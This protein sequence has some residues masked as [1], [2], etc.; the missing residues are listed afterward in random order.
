MNTLQR[1]KVIILA[2]AVLAVAFGLV[3]F[4]ITLKKPQQR[5]QQPIYTTPT[6]S[7]LPPTAFTA[8]TVVGFSPVDQSTNIS[9][10]ASVSAT[11]SRP[12]TEAEKQHVS[13]ATAPVT[14]GSLNWSQNNTV[15]TFSPTHL[16]TNTSYQ[17]S[18]IFGSQ[19]IHWSFTTASD[20]NLSQ[21]DKNALQLQSDDQFGAWQQNVYNNYPWYDN[22]PLQT[23]GYFTYFDLD[24]KSFISDLYGDPNDTQTMNNLKQ[25]ILQK[26]QSLGV[27]ITM[28]KFVWNITPA[29]E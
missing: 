10:F 1:I 15:V 28:Y 16:A 8:L 14:P 29:S 13:L 12:I 3:L 27:N 4:A 24:T 5:I 11:F 18:L 23:A 9:L 17:A 6:P 21:N 19:S 26:I 2:S 22:F 7:P 25:E 20:A